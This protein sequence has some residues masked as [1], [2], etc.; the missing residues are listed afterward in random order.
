MRFRPR[1]LRTRLISGV[2]ALL[3]LACL[4]VGLATTFALRRFLID[5]VDQQLGMSPGRLASSLEHGRGGDTRG[6]TVGTL[7]AR[8]AGGR[9]THAAVV[10]DGGAAPTLTPADQTTLA[11]VPVDD[12]EHTVEL[13]ALDDYRVIAVAGS[14]GDVLITGLPL[15]GVNATVRRLL[16]LEFMVF[17]VSLGV[18]GTAGALWI[19]SSLRPLSRMAATAARV[20]ELPLATGQVALP[21]RVPDADGATEVG[22][23]S[24]ALNRML[25]HVE[26]A[27][28][29]RHAGEQRLRRFIAEAS[30]ELRTPLAGIRGHA[31]LAQ[32]IPG[33]VPDDVR[34]SLDRIQGEAVR[35]GALVD[36]LLLLAR[37]DAGRPLARDEVDL[38]RLV[39]DSA[40]DARA[41]GPRHQWRL[42]LPGEPV[43]VTGDRSRLQQVLANLL[44]NSRVHTPDGTT[45][46]VRLC[47][48]GAGAELTIT[49][50]GPG[51]P[52]EVQGEIFD[53]FA[54]ADRNRSRPGGGS[55]LGLAIVQAVVV[56]H[57][58]T[59]D[60][61]SHPGRTVFSV[62]LGSPETDLPE[63]PL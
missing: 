60:V 25:R 30:H 44:A 40:S 17:A 47:S 14:D 45:V 6:Q 52:A 20:A 5:R 15:E 50:D 41:A 62:R 19:R 24:A 42:E 51:I 61:D 48:A 54:Q 28:A 59:V 39:L 29:Q 58:G 33:S 16:A 27:L 53:R 13:S 12:R 10:T 35:M 34:H 63:R 21:E 3:A 31:E 26:N 8:M 23:V 32:R 37:L 46:T 2:L 49:D 55:G 11:A 18:T 38:T 7:G 43:V 4:A 9:I 57:G 36:D 1:S 56:A 22:Q